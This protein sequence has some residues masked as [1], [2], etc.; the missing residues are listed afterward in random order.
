M[1]ALIFAILVAYITIVCIQ[2]NKEIPEHARGGSF[3]ASISSSLVKTSSALTWSAKVDN[4]D[5]TNSSA[6]FLQRYYVDETYWD[7]LGPIFLDIGGEG[8]LGGTPGGYIAQLA[9]QY[10]ALIVALE[11]RYYGESIPNNSMET[12]NLKYLTVEQ[13]LADLDA[14]TRWFTSDFQTN[15]SPWFVFG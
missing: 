11:H 3:Y 15:S 14:F 7:G 6:T 10:N 9:S 12:I 5:T 4:F 8:T 1:M 2:G 13:A